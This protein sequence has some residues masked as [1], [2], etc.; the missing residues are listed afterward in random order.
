MPPKTARKGSPLS[1]ARRLFMVLSWLA[2]LL[3]ALPA[4]AQ[5][6]AGLDRQP[7]PDWVEDLPAPV[8]DPATEAQALDGVHYILSDHQLRWQGE[9]SQSHARTVLKVIDRAGLE[10]AATLRFDL[11]PT[12]ETLALTRLVILRD[13][14]EIDLR[15]R[16]PAEV[17]RREERL[18][19]GVI[20]GTLTVWMQIPDLRVGD[21]V[22]YSTL[23]STRP[24]VPGGER[25]VISVLEWGVPVQL[26]RTVVLWPADWPMRAEPLPDR[27]VQVSGPAPDGTVRHEWQRLGHLPDRW[28]DNIPA[29]L[30]PEAVL[31]LTALDW[32]QVA[33]ALTPHYAADYPLTPEWEARLPGLAALPTAQARTIAALRMVQD[34]LRYVSLSVG[35]GGY[36]ARSPDQVIASG[37]GDC[38][39]KALL[40]AVMLRRLGI[41]AAVALTDAD[42]GR[43]LD[44]RVPM[45]A[46]FDHAILRVRVD[47]QDHWLDPT[48]SHQ[49]GDLATATPPGFDWALPLTGADATLEPIP[50]PPE[51][52]WATDVTE[53]YVF[54][55]L[56]VALEVR[57]VYG[58]G[59]A[60]AMRA[61]WATTP[62]AQISLDYLD[63]YLG[64]Y[65]GLVMLRQMEKTDDRAANR[66]EMVERYLLPKDQ[67]A[68]SAVERSF[69]FGTEDFASNLPDRLGFPRRAPLD[70]GGPAL[71]RHRVRV[72]GAP[73]EFAA[74]PDAT[75]ENPAFRM[76]F[77]GADAPGGTLDL[78]WEFRRSGAV[79]A[80]QDAARVIEDGNRVYDLTWFTWDVSPDSVD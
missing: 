22:D 67:L 24:T 2:W 37:F 73:M 12:H 57:S 54:T 6:P 79:V 8:S 39:D 70:A 5:A 42:E 68:G 78:R 65:P 15:D 55:A 49:G 26:A 61:R 3:P 18:D 74:P 34:E 38:K 69:P 19:E 28:E 7:L 60:D 11:D 36:F 50:A 72:Q 66:F 51:R 77:A 59:A 27:V 33:A 45:L 17:L 46:A 1:P 56:G 41:E 63:Y 20:D 21:V 9:D 23:R 4:L 43:V 52:A 13:G 14:Q 25:Q 62:A 80:P 16:L 29:G 75:I 31:R 64:R 30:E 32:G 48:A 35:A 58:G 44:R 47:G 10:R 76:V 71:F 53:T 40:L